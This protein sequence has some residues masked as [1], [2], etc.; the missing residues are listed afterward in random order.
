MT[1]S[2][3][4][5]ISS[6]QGPG[7]SHPE[8]PS[9]ARESPLS[10]S[11]LKGMTLQETEEWCGALG[12]PPYRARQIRQWLFKQLVASFHEMENLPKGL[13]DDLSRSGP[14]DCLERVTT[15]VSADGTE[16]TLF[17]LNDGPHIESV[18][19]PERNHKTLCISSQAG[20]AM[21]CRFC[22][23]GRGGLRR[24][25]RAGE[26]VDQVVQVRR[27]MVEPERLRNIVFMGMGEPLANV[28]EVLRA[29]RILVADDGLNFSHRKITVS[30][31]GL[32]PMMERLGRETSVNLAVSLNAADDETRT[33]L[34]P[35]NR[36]YPMNTLLTACREFPLPNRRMI[37]FE[38]ILIR[39]VND[40]DRDARNL[41]EL[42][43]GIRAK[44]NLIPLNPDSEMDML[45]STPDRIQAFQ[46][47]LIQ[48]HYTAIIRKSKGQDI[49][50][51]CGQLSGEAE[52]RPPSLSPGTVV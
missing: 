21:G 6:R 2:R 17:R 11:D 22:V 23:T 24:N 52:R 16:K 13:R 40:R 18:L 49:S 31:S 38:Y 15:Q 32:V 36:R 43:R 33:A 41:A 50:A 25:L 39:G 8:T 26:I 3:E 44:I 37:T 19:I 1:G 10:S 7:V 35:V 12:L 5:D 29:I 47:V 20:C 46:D 42:L 30:T 28:D 4:P 45:P 27:S 34:M 48:H 51:A 9:P 14:V